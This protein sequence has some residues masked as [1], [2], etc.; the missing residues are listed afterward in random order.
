MT[1]ANSRKVADLIGPEL[2]AWVARA[3]GIEQIAIN[4]G[5]CVVGVT[6]NR[7]VFTP[8][9]NP[10]QGQPIMERERIGVAWAQMAGVWYARPNAWKA[11]PGARVL[12]EGPTM[13]VAGM[14]AWVWTIYGDEVTA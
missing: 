1:S 3:E 13:L 9:M 7:Y 12:Q 10:A 14:R 5:H 11:L 2:D 8:S 4:D 6:P